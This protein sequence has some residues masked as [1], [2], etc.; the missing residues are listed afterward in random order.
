MKFIVERNKLMKPLQK[1]NGAIHNKP[2]LP[3]LNN[4][5]LQVKNGFLFLTTTDL[6]IE[7]VATIF[8]KEIYEQGSITVSARKLF[9][10]C[11]NLSEDSVIIFSLEEEKMIIHSQRSKFILST[12]PAVNF[13]NLH[14]WQKK[15]EFTLQKSKFKILLESTQ[16]SMA[17][18]DVRYYLNGMLLEIKN[19]ILRT[20]T[21]DGHRLSICSIIIDE[22]LTNNSVILPRKCVH[23]LLRLINNIHDNLIIQIGSNNIKFNFENFTFTSKLIDGD[24]PDYQRV[25]PKQLNKRMEVNCDLL[26]KSLTRAAILSNETSRGIRFNIN[27]NQLMITTHNREQEELE[28]ILDVQYDGDDLEISFNVNYIL[29]VLNH[30]KCSNIRLL[31]SDANSSVHIEDTLNKNF[32]YIIMPIKL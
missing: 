2:I 21:T 5:L 30:I 26:K 6:E 18:Q 31:F 28:E 12:I 4:I 22:L 25:L 20:V 15:I 1:V 8:L 10:I 24:F 19:K 29:D 14:Q 7:M 3:I 17:C 27:S 16:F 23:E 13:P 32:I 9:D 11:K